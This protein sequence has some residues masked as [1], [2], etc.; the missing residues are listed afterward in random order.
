MPDFHGLTSNP[1]YEKHNHPLV[2]ENRKEL[3]KYLITELNDVLNAKSPLILV[4]LGGIG[5]GK[6]FTLKELVEKAR[7]QKEFLPEKKIIAIKFDATVAGP[8]SNYIQFMFYSTMKCMGKSKFE[9]LRTEFDKESIDPNVLAEIEECFRNA[10]LNFKNK[11]NQ[12][13]IWKWLVGEKTDVKHL[14]ELGIISK[15]DNSFAMDAFSAF[16][17]LLEKLGYSGLF[18]CIDEAEELAL[19]GTSQVVK[20]L[21]QIKKVFEQN[22]NQLSETSPAGIPIVFCLAFTPGTYKLITGSRTAEKETER[23]GSAGLQTFLRRIG[24]EYYIDPLSSRDIEEL[25]KVLL[26]QARQE[27]TES[28][29]PFQKKAV[30]YLAE[31]SNGAPGYFMQYAKEVLKKADELHIKNIDAEKT[32]KWLVEAGLIPVEGLKPLEESPKEVDI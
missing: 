19:S 1:F 17:I 5:V 20:V 10:F 2:G 27:K 13:D 28:I 8:A 24:K 18:L 22:K 3:M 7:N 32:N 12:K 4:L 14:K 15:I 23:T 30:K 21:T 31:I 26:N 29:Y 16:S 9:H 25:V 11:E 6:S